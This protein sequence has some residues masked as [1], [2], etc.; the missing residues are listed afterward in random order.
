MYS[1]NINKISFLVK[2]A[3]HLPYTIHK[4]PLSSPLSLNSEAPWYG[5]KY[6]T[7]NSDLF[8][9]RHEVPLV[10]RG[11]SSA[12]NTLIHTDYDGRRP[13]AVACT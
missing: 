10:L 6:C 5:N 1:W 9:Q 4:H 2:K 13:A 8:P 12:M 3:Q 11:K 7:N